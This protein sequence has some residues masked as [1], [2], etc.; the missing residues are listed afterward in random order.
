MLEAIAVAHGFNPQGGT[1][2]YAFSTHDTHL[3]LCDAIRILKGYRKKLGYFLRAESYQIT[4]MFIHNRSAL[5]SRLLCMNV[6]N[7]N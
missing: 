1:K 4:V 6:E 3:K 5:L 2:N 7:E